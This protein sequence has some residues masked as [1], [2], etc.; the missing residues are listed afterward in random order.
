MHE[1]YLELYIQFG[2]ILLFMVTYPMA[3]FWAWVNNVLE[4][5][6]DAF[7][8]TRTQR[9]PAVHRVGHIG[10]WQVIRPLPPPALLLLL[11][12]YILVIV[13]GLSYYFCFCRFCGISRSIVVEL[14]IALRAFRAG[15]RVE[16][17]ERVGRR[18]KRK[19]GF[20]RFLWFFVI[21]VF[22]GT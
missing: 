7:K 12:A 4:L 3:A 2:Y 8:L 22:L 20:L 14:S 19:G 21:L 17:V 1:D 5:R 18:K 15:E 16:G 11:F 10:A 9:R 13:F 6:V